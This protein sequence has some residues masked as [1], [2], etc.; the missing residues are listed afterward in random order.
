MQVI[1]ELGVKG[2]TYLLALETNLK[3][4][5]KRVTRS[6]TCEVKSKII[7]ERGLNVVQ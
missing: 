3:K 7:V 5:F 6:N 1:A 2:F 4:M